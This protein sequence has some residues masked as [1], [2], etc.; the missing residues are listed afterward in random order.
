MDHPKHSSNLQPIQILIVDDMAQV[1]ADLR[2]LLELSEMLKVVGEAASGEEAILQAEA[3]RPQVIL[4]DL[5]MP[6]LDGYQ[7]T[8]RIKANTPE[9]RVIA[10]SVH[11]YEQARQKA[12]DC[13]ADGFIEKGTLLPEIVRKIQE[14]WDGERDRGE[15]EK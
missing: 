9:C 14:V 6:G 11:S 8:Q 1:L 5:K 2:S 15:N 13:G 3:L 7:A 4:M 12:S 10:L